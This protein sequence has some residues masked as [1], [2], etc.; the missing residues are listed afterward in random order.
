MTIELA[1]VPHSGIT[2]LQIEEVVPEPSTYALLLGGLGLL[3]F[4]RR[5]AFRA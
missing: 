3:A 5:R 2:G 1:N 4:L